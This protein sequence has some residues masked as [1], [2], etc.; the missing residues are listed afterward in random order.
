MNFK[1]ALFLLSLGAFS[2]G[3]PG[4][5]ETDPLL[6]ELTAYWPLNQVNASTSDI[7]GG[8]DL[9][10]V[11]GGVAGTVAAP[12]GSAVA[13]HGEDVLLGTVVG[14]PVYFEGPFSISIRVRADG[15]GQGNRHL[16]ALGS[17]TNN[18]P[19]FSIGAD[20]TGE[21]GSVAVFFRDNAGQPRLPYAKST[22]P[23]LDG[24]WRHLVWVDDGGDARLYVDGV[25]DETDFSYSRREAALNTV[26]IGGALRAEAS[27]FFKGEVGEV[28]VWNR[29][30]SDGEV[31]LLEREGLDVGPVEA[32]PPTLTVE[33]FVSSI[34]AG[35][36]LVLSAEATGTRPFTY[37]WYAGEDA[38]PAATGATLELELGQLDIAPV[39]SVE[40]ANAAGE[41][42]SDAFE[43]PFYV[44]ETLPIPD[45]IVLEVGGMDFTDD[46]TLLIATHGRGEVWGLRDG[47]WSLFAEG[48]HEPL[49][50]LVTG[51]GEIVVAQRP[52]L[53]RI[54]DTTGDGVADLYET[55]T[56]A[57]N[58]SGHMYEYV[59]GPVKDDE[60]NLWGALAY[61]FIAGERFHE[62]V[63]S[64]GDIPLLLRRPI[65]PPFPEPAPEYR[66]WV[67][68]VTPEGEFVPWAPGV[69]SPNGLAF[70]PEGELFVADN[71]GEY[72][73]TSPVLHVS[74]GDF[75]GYPIGLLWDESFE[76][77]PT[78]LSMDELDAMRKPA[79][80]L[81]PHGEMGQ[82]P[83]EPRWDNTGGQFGP[84]SGQMFLGDQTRSILM[85]GTLEKVQGEYQG[86]VYPFREGFHSGNN[87]LVF[88]P[89]G[90]LY[91]GQTSRGWRSEGGG[92]YGL[93]RMVWTGRVP[94]EVSEMALS[95]DGFELTF[96]RPLDFET[97]SDPD[98]YSFLHYHYH[99][100]KSYGSP[101]V[102]P[103]EVAVE[104]VMVFDGG[105]R[106]SLIL[107]ALVRGKIY[108][109]RLDGLRGADGST[110]LNPSA[111]YTLNYLLDESVPGIALRSSSSEGSEAE[112]AATPEGAATTEE[113]SSAADLEELTEAEQALFEDGRQL[114]LAN[115]SSCHHATGQGVE[116]VAPS[117]TGSEWLPGPEEAVVKILLNGKMGEAMMMPPFSWLLDEDLA[118]LATYLRREWHGETPVTPETV[119][120][121]RDE[122]SSRTQVWT[123][124]ELR[125]LFE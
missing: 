26:A 58:Y 1:R 24:E 51:P 31:E 79:A 2:L 103:T 22:Q 91:I 123:D 41:A 18:S 114:Y 97:A 119:G 49:G 80:L 90:S 28:A 23:V 69:R 68:K 84:F 75:L 104:E 14:S 46:G 10:P 106:V 48:L 34:R 88:G 9:L 66:G 53:T 124:A 110:L 65:R 55:I 52:E 71:Q 125:A 4:K 33:P 16:F 85:R 99:Y 62:D 17:S 105:R 96:T 89:D 67:F 56:D 100:H 29:A 32:L 112:G 59:F 108:E 47:E 76:G 21:T 61:W 101:K 82:S 40:I 6:E 3:N 39:Y 111:F 115:C 20:E 77:D 109:L 83:S 25:L 13:F 44:L 107:P 98:N 57:W 81:P 8:Y 118:A 50:L 94:L 117:L 120:E 93:Q 11:G 95:A 37:Q 73:G 74:E 116:G 87:R 19:F 36:D 38:I 7:V 43:I 42:R 15:I 70:N 122:S 5:A 64:D 78:A 63:Y 60:G 86:A 54:T 113:I 102:D 30:L 35:N 72:L 92:S 27:G 45:D 121:I 12:G